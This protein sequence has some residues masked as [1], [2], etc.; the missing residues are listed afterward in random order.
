MPMCAAAMAASHPAWPAPT[1]MMSKISGTDG[2]VIIPLPGCQNALGIQ[3][4]EDGEDLF[5]DQGREAQGGFVEEEQARGFGRAY[6]PGRI[7][8]NSKRSKLQ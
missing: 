2:M 4:V 1:T 8:A 3:G 7:P 5:D 6:A